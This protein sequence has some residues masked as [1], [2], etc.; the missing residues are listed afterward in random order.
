MDFTLTE[1]MRMIQEMTRDFARKECAPIAA[2]VD[3]SHRFPA[4]TIARMAELGL[5]GIP[6]PAEWGGAGMDTRCY[7]I[8]V[9]EIS[10]AC[11][12]TG[13][14][15]SIHTSTV[16]EPINRF[17][18]EE[19]KRRYLAPL[20]GGRWIGCF[21]L[22]EA[23]SG[24][25]AAAL[26]TSARNAGDRWVLNG[27][28]LFVTNSKEAR[29]CLLFA[30]TDLSGGH[31]AIN[32]YLVEMD[33]PGISIGQYEEK[34]GIRGT[35]TMEIVLQDVEVP[36][37]NLL[38]EEGEGFKIAMRALDAGRIG[39]AAQAVGIGR[40]ALEE[41]VK[42]A[43][44]R[45][46]FGK[47]ISAFQAIQWKVADMATEIDAA[48][49]LTWRAAWLKDQGMKHTRQSAMAKLYASEAAMR[50]ATEAIQIH[51]G[52]GY[53]KEYPV[54]RYYRDAKVCEIY[55]GTSEI[56]RLVIASSLSG[57]LP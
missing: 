12:A 34:M 53:V 23:W 39:I 50:A 47:P 54:E 20:A 57:E 30:T 31:R 3:Q 51:G 32:A 33:T 22:T 49:L 36:R 15:V 18:T 21:A 52:Y 48:R 44:E 37:E 8:A 56:Q 45:H 10:R 7:A 42:Y 26:R 28:K 17:G 41:S 6:I 24:S 19:Q 27:T 14:V 38:G 55:E 43:R 2:E 46:Q 5:L 4:E 25:D 9:E 16:C 35:S 11:A 29:V 40:A 1:E 13:A